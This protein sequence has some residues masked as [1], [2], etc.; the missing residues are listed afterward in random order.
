VPEVALIQISDV[1]ADA[2][3]L[4]AAQSTRASEVAAIARSA[5]DLIRGR[6]IVAK[7][8]F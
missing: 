1:D 5:R 2:V 8:L 7:I 3:A 4:D 6:A